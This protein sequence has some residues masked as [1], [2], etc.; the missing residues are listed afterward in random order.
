MHT[1]FTSIDLE[2]ESGMAFLRN[3]CLFDWNIIIHN[4]E[5]FPDSMTKNPMLNFLWAERSYEFIFRVKHFSK[6]ST[7]LRPCSKYHQKACRDIALQSKIAEEFNCQIPIFYSGRHLDGHGWEVLPICNTSVTSKAIKFLDHDFGCY[8]SFPCEHTDYT[9]G[10]FRERLPD[11]H[12]SQTHD[13]KISF[14]QYLEYHKAY[15]SVDEQALIGQVGG[16]SGILLGWSGKLLF[17]G[18]IKGLVKIII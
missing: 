10:R 13:V 16:I 11:N 3:N 5:D 6:S 12:L 7:K 17:D 14:R 9:I 4:E 8:K 18:V 15:V 1:T 2:V